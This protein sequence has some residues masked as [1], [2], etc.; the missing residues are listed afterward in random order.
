V[1]SVATDSKGNLY[2]V[3]TLQG[4]RLQKFTYKGLGPIPAQA[5]KVV[6]PGAGR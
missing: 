4:K 2:T 5:P 6:W 3:E 1:H